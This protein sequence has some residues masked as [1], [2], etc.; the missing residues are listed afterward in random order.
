MKN[1]YEF[2]QIEIAMI[3]A[4][5][6]EIVAA[7]VPYYDAPGKLSPDDAQWTDVQSTPNNFG[8]TWVGAGYTNEPHEIQVKL[9]MLKDS[10]VQLATP[11]PKEDG[12]WYPVEDIGKAISAYYNPQAA[13]PANQPPLP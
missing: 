10:N 11:L 7:R 13:T 1:L 2:F 6:A 3:A 5:D 4:G 9:R 8:R 12:A